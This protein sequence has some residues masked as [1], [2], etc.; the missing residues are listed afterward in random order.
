MDCVTNGN[1]SSSARRPGGTFSP[2]RSVSVD[3]HSLV[4]PSNTREFSWTP[5]ANRS[6]FFL[7]FRVHPIVAQSL[8]KQKVLASFTARD[9]CV[10]E[11]D[12][13]TLAIQSHFHTSS[14]N[15]TMNFGRGA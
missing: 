14:I 11:I 9:E 1:K 5:L 4:D 15:T 10:L 12:G 6:V 7:S 13:Q 3:R 2:G 8:T